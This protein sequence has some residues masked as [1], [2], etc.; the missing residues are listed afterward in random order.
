M[1]VKHCNLGRVVIKSEK[2]KKKFFCK[3]CGLYSDTKIFPPHSNII[4]TIFAKHRVQYDVHMYYSV[5]DFSRIV[6]IPVPK[7]ISNLIHIHSIPLL[8]MTFDHYLVTVE[9]YMLILINVSHLS[10]CI[11]ILDGPGDLSLEIK[12]L[13]NSRNV[14]SHHMYITS[15]YQATIHILDK[16]KPANIRRLQQSYVYEQV[17][18]TPFSITTNQPV[19]R[20]IDIPRSLERTWLQ[21]I[22]TSDLMRFNISIE[23]MSYK[24]NDNT[25]CDIAGTTVYDI[26]NDTYKAIST[27]CNLP[28]GYPHRNIYSKSSKILLVSYQHVEYGYMVH[29]LGVSTTKCT[30]VFLNPCVFTSSEYYSQF[31]SKSDPNFILPCI[32][33]PNI[34]HCVHLLNNANLNATSNRAEVTVPEGTCA[35]ILIDRNMEDFYQLILAKTFSFPSF[36][37]SC[38]IDNFQHSIILEERGNIDWFVSGFL[39]GKAM[40]NIQLIQSIQTT[41][42]SK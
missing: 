5:I 7:T 4:N 30:I 31:S 41:G 28:E 14:D 26:I 36:T 16:M 17:K 8:N 21:I 37:G 3:L 24:G 11:K 25:F 13:N 15:S 18:N 9:K 23:N 12:P 35:V 39:S 2:Q 38:F 1:N 27:F 33:E 32:K 20:F 40:I 42:I 10:C 22:V 6:S 19:L 34:P 29:T